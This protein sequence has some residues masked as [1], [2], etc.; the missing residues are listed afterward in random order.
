MAVKIQPVPP[1]AGFNDKA[2]FVYRFQE[3]IPHSVVY[4]ISAPNNLLREFLVP[5]R[6]SPRPG[7]DLQDTSRASNHPVHPVILSKNLASDST[8]CDRICEWPSLASFLGKG[9]TVLPITYLEQKG[10]STRVF[11]AGAAV[12]QKPCW[13]RRRWIAWRVPHSCRT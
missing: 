6:F 7:R 8:M 12:I 10:L 11:V 5:H 4:A 3:S 9:P 13:R 2:F 1:S